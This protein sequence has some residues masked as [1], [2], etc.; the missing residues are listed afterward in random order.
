MQ[1]RD[2]RSKISRAL[3]RN[4]RRPADAHA[5]ERRVGLIQDMA[6]A[7]VSRGYSRNYWIVQPSSDFM[8]DASMLP[9]TGSRICRADEICRALDEN[10]AGSGQYKD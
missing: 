2:L 3:Q 7:A 1:V 5:L 10:C 8:L 9:T 6:E 4:L